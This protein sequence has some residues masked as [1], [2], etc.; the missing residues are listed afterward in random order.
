[1]VQQ[2]SKEDRILRASD[3]IEKAAKTI[4]AASLVINNLR[5]DKRVCKKCNH[6]KSIEEFPEVVAYYQI[7]TGELKVHRARRHTCRECYH[8]Q[9]VKAKEHR[10]KKTEFNYLF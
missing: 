2:E 5:Q 10:C 1:M 7:K 6:E 9:V 4:Q 8:K 3:R